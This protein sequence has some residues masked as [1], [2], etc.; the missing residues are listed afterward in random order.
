[1]FMRNKDRGL[2]VCCQSLPYPTYTNKT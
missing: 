2:E 1:M